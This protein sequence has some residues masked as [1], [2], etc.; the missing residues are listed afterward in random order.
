MYENITF[1]V[2]E[3][4]FFDLQNFEVIFVLTENLGFKLGREI[5]FYMFALNIF[6]RFLINNKVAFLFLF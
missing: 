6:T 4:L 5:E 2:S 3:L 1:I